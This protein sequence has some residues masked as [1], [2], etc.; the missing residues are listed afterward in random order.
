M[1]WLD[2]EDFPIPFEQ[3]VLAIWKGRVGVL[4][5]VSLKAGYFVYGPAEGR[6]FGDPMDEEC[7]AR[8]NYWHPLPT[9]IFKSK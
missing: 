7:L 9:V 4:Y 1:Y 2:R 5:L 6:K 8:I 3:E